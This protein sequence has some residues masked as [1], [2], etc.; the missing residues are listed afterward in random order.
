MFRFSSEAFSHPWI[1]S[2]ASPY[3]MKRFNEW[4]VI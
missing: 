4:S 1:K 3:K 2:N